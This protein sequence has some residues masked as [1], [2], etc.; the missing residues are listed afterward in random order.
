VYT[1]RRDAKDYD[2]LFIVKVKELLKHAFSASVGG[3]SLVVCPY[4]GWTGTL[5]RRTSQS[6][7]KASGSGHY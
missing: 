6:M 1:L 4:N 2:F 7:S 3:H 5:T